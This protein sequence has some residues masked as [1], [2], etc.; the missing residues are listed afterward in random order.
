MVV[1]QQSE[2][3]NVIKESF[4]SKHINEI[5]LN[6]RG[7]KRISDLWIWLASAAVQCS[8]NSTKYSMFYNQV[9][10]RFLHRCKA[11]SVELNN[12]EAL[13]VRLAG[14]LPHA[15]MN[16]ATLLLQ[17]Q[18]NSWIFYLQTNLMHLI[19]TNMR[20]RS[21]KFGFR[22]VRLVQIFTLLCCFDVITL[23]AKANHK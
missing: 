6:F 18:R 10:Q 21:H 20:V 12:A 19:A 5:E 3:N 11:R 1:G 23:G 16:H 7:P 17:K 13:G 4:I 2:K 14:A 15:A 8:T 22:A 9:L